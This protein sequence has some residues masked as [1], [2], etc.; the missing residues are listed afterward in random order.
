MPNNKIKNLGFCNETLH[1]DWIVEKL[2]FT[3]W[4]FWPDRYSR[5]KHA[6][7]NIL[8]WKKQKI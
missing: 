6:A 5:T 2:Y 7:E 3:C 4:A 8:A 1:F